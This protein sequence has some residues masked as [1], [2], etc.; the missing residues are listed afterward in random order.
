MGHLSPEVLLDLAE[1]A[2]A[3][4]DAHLAVCATCRGEVEALRST[5]AL[6]QSA[7]VPE[8]SPLFWDH[9]SAR[10]KT[11]VEAD[12]LRQPAW[13]FTRSGWF[14]GVLAIAAALVIAV[15]L[16]SRGPSAPVVGEPLSDN[17]PRIEAALPAGGDPLA[18][19]DAADDPSLSLLVDLAGELDWE[20]AASGLAVRTGIG[21]GALSNLDDD[22]RTELGRLLREELGSAGV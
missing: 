15:V 19:P 4:A 9:L 22:E 17:P 18:L 16:V 12:A 6:A 7:T 13:A 1:G 2:P 10:V 5:I 11:A 8:P 3:A 21:D 20:V 14:G